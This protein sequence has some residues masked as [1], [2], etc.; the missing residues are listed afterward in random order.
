MTVDNS[1]SF[2]YKVALVGKT[3]DALNN[4]NRSVKN[5]KTVAPLKYPSNFWRLLEMPLNHCKV[6]LEL[7]RIEDCILFSNGD[8]LK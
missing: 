2:K 6:H 5:T 8:S 1:Q 4:T 7:N 3:A